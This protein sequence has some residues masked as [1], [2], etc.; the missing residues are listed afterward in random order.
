MAFTV[1]EARRRCQGEPE[2][3]KSNQCRCLATK[4]NHLF[5]F[6]APRNGQESSNEQVAAAFSARAK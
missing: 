1:V 5:A 2:W 3:L 4:L 6:Y